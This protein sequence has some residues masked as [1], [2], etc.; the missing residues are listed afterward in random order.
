[1]EEHTDEEVW[2]VIE[3]G[4]KHWHSTQMVELEDMSEK[5]KSE[6][7]RELKEGEAFV[8]LARKVLENARANVVVL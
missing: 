5:A 6:K 2:S 1:M 4:L 3:Q 7:L 8:E